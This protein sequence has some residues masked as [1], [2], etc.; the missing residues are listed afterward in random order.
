M[1]IDP[2]PVIERSP[3]IQIS[4]YP[5]PETGAVTESKIV[6]RAQVKSITVNG[7]DG[8][9][10]LI[11]DTSI[12]IKLSGVVSEQTHGGNAGRFV[13][14]RLP[15]SAPRVRNHLFGA[16]DRRADFNA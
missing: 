5:S 14:R 4:T 9:D 1:L 3:G 16:R 6:P 10:T 2:L 12:G 13:N 7:G 15:D 11:N 8:N